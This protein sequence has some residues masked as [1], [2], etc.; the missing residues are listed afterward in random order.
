MRTLVAITFA[1]GLA[2]HAHAECHDPPVI[3]PPH[4]ARLPPYPTVLV[5]M[6]TPRYHELDIRTP[7]STT[8]VGSG[9][10]FETVRVDLYAARGDVQLSVHGAPRRTHFSRYQIGA[11]EPNV[12]AVTSVTRGGEHVIDFMLRG[13]AIGLRFAFDDGHTTIVA[14]DKGLARLGLVPCFG[15]NIDAKRLATD[16]GFALSALFPDGSEQRIGTSRLQLDADTPAM[17]MPTDLVGISRGE[18]T[19]V[20][21][22]TES[23][24]M[25]P[26][27]VHPPWSMA[28]V[29]AL[30]GITVAVGASLLRRRRAHEPR[31]TRGATR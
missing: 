7:H 27:V 4:G 6:P 3:A 13:N 22:R 12:V 9:R 25:A 17:Q 24:S 10:D 2:S 18:P 26:V 30:G 29:G 31:Y 28:L 1:V 8:S 16:R 14:I 11:A 5:T 19:E 23:A 20:I 15:W 21:N